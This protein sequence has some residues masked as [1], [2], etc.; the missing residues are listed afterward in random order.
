M[1]P[2]CSAA[3][4]LVPDVLRPDLRVVFCGTALGRAS[5]EAKAYYAHPRNV[6]WSILHETGLTFA[7]RPLTPSEYLRVLEFGVGL[8]DLCKS[9]FGNDNDL[10]HK[11]FDIDAL[12]N[13]VED[14]RPA[15]LAFT[16]KKAGQA[17]CGPRAVL[18]WQDNVFPRTRVYILPSTSPSARWQWVE[19][20]FHWRILADQVN[21][22]ELAQRGSDHGGR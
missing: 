19:N 8:T 21:G 6:F 4:H 17:F 2:T 9:M 10:P 11:A 3:P 7:G 16:S 14:Y 1:S 15:V 20:K 22:L 5:A 18:G 12:R 13:K